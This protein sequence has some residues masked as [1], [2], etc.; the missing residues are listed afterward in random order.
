MLLV[1]SALSDVDQALSRLRAAG[2]SP[3]VIAG[4]KIHFCPVLRSRMDYL[5]RSGFIT[6]KDRS[7]GI[8]VI[9]AEKEPV[10]A[11]RVL[12]P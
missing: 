12:A 8:V 4:Q 7:D 1:H 2:L 6:S 3:A 11:P 9:G 5:V 10:R